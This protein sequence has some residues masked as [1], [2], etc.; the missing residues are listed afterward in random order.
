MIGFMEENINDDDDVLDD[1][2]VVATRL[3]NMKVPKGK[4]GDTLINIWDKVKDC[5]GPECGLYK[6]CPYFKKKDKIAI[7][8]KR[9]KEGK[10]LGICRVEQKYMHYNIQPFLGLLQKIPD[11]F[12]VQTVGMHLIPLYHDL[13]QL[14]MEKARISSVTYSDSKGTIRI[15]PVY[16]QLLKTHKAIMETWRNSGLQTLAK[17]VGF[18]T[19]KRMNLSPSEADLLVNGDGVSY[20]AMAGDLKG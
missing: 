13:V 7:A 2:K 10:S 6:K 17:E 15:H 9:I 14:K 18:F 12:V 19:K 5:T 20:E 16:D 1:L 11:D 8:E 3:Y 4:I